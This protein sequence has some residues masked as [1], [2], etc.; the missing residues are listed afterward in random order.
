MENIESILDQ[1]LSEVPWKL[2][3]QDLLDLVDHLVEETGKNPTFIKMLLN[4]KLLSFSRK[5]I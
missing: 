2:D 5:R 1:I 3:N 4:K